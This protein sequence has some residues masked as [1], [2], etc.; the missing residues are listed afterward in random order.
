LQLAENLLNLLLH[1]ADDRDGYEL[2][3]KTLQRWYVE[4]LSEKLNGRGA[5]TDDDESADSFP[6][7]RGQLRA[8]LRHSLIVRRAGKTPVASWSG[9]EE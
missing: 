3:V 7:L 1:R 6:A 5:V 8:G 2:L 9:L 4:L